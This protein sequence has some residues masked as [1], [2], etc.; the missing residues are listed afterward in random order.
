MRWLV[1]LLAAGLASAAG[2]ATTVQGSL[3]RRADLG[4]R[5]IEEGQA[6]KVEPARPAIPGRAGGIAGRRRDRRDR[7]PALRARL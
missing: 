5:G 1:G 6:L 4:F 3:E 7:R 2:A